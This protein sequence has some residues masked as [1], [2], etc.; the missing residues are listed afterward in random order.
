MTTLDAVL[1]PARLEPQVLARHADPVFDFVGHV[2][3]DDFVLPCTSPDRRARCEA[4][5]ANGRFFVP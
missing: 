5:L 3:G 1:R 2:G 4:L